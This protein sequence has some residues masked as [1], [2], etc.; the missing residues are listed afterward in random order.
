M[1]VVVVVEVVLVFL[2]LLLLLYMP[3]CHGSVVQKVKHGVA[4]IM[5]L[6]KIDAFILNYF[7]QLSHSF[8]F[9]L[10]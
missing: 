1:V 6:C 4:L 3:S 10:G 9:K 7:V 8:C 2:L 5:N